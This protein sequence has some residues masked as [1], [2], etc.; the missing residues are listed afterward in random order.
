MKSI[1]LKVYIYLKVL[2]YFFDGLFQYLAEPV[3]RIFSPDQDVHPPVIGVQP[4]G[5]D[6]YSK[7]E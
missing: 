1:S 2:L 5:G 3:S 4:Y 6:Y 7:W